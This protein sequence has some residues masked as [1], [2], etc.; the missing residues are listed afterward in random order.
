MT[1]ITSISMSDRLYNFLMT[2][3]EI[4]PSNIVQNELTKVSNFII[5][6]ENQNLVLRNRLRIANMA[7][8]IIAEELEGTQYSDIVSP[9][10]TK[11]IQRINDEDNKKNVI[12]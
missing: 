9:A 7:L 3:P 6:S 1:K 11:A 10:T 8:T 12:V 2:H 4:S 5:D